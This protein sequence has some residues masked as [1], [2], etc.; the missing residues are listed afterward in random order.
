MLILEKSIESAIQKYRQ[1]HLTE[2]ETLS[3]VILHQNPQHLDTLT[4]LALIAQKKGQFDR[5]ESLY[6]QI[7]Q[8]QPDCMMAYGALGDLY[9][10]RYPNRY[11][12]A[13]DAYQTVLTL[14]PPHS[15]ALN[16]YNYLGKAF[17]ESGQFEHAIQAYQQV[18]ELKEDE[19]FGYYNLGNALAKNTKYDEAI[20][21]YKKA[22]E[23]KPDYHEAYSNLGNILKEKG[24]RAEAIEAYEKAIEIKPDFERPRFGILSNQIPIV[25]TSVEE[26]DRRRKSYTQYL[27]SLIERYQSATPEERAIYA[28]GVG[29]SQPF[30]LAYQGLND[31]PLQQ[32]YG[33]AIVSLMQSR[34]PQWSQPPELPPLKDG[35]KIRVG[36]VSAFF[37][38][39][40]NWKIPIQGWVE[41]IDKSRFQLFGYYCDLKQDPYTKRA[42]RSFTK[43]EMGNRS[44]E[45]W[46]QEIEGD[47]LH[48]LIF[49]EFGMHST[50][51]QLGCLRL[52]PI[53]MTSW[54]H[55]QTS[56]L[57]TIDYYLSSDLM[58]P[59]DA[60]D[61]YTE[62]VVRLPNL[63][64]FYP[65]FKITPTPV[66]RSDIGVK[67]SDTLFWCCQSIY[68][69]LPQHD[70]I[71][72]KIA[73]SLPNAKFLFIQYGRGQYVTEI[74]YQRLQRAFA[75]FGLDATQSC[76]F[77]PRMKAKLF[78]G[79][80]AI[81][82]VFL[83]SIG[84]SGC[85]STLESLNHNLPILTLPGD[86]MRGRHTLDILKMMGVDD[87][88]AADKEE[89]V[90]LAVRL[91]RDPEYRQQISE[92]IAA[93]KHRVYNDLQPVRALEGFLA[94]TVSEKIGSDRASFH[95]NR[96]T[97]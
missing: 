58:E 86:L 28:D 52:A 16:T 33:R 50:T 7:L 59:E 38:S 27:Q 73:R 25:Y 21:A 53:Q 6:R 19:A 61:N 75:E 84:W 87:T 78:A 44:L 10:F 55:P 4:L 82:D 39:H 30:Y 1:G 18:I 85:N 71:F 65:P 40:S 20:E 63:S 34:Y 35:E 17:I 51:L 62:N 60:A 67:E 72:P 32:I 89:Y 81:S 66:S 37:Y 57:P 13:I 74:F 41:N 95:G 23:L 9:L 91:G 97:D 70:D 54:G 90:N 69:Y 36:I 76:I 12:D 24:E 83:D 47:R 14:N 80:S 49:P 64:I 15:A 31:R 92:K 5:A 2:A 11:Q 42:A 48:V 96:E 93:N 26:I 22:I 8:I 68:K 77:L 43:F 88:I 79:M 56:G 29:A 46:C 94:R 45:Q 3:E